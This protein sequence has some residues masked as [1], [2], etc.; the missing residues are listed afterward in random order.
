MTILPRLI[1]PTSR[2]PARATR[3]GGFD[4]SGAVRR[5]ANSLRKYQDIPLRLHK[6]WLTTFLGSLLL[7]GVV[8]GI[9]LNLTARTAIA[10]REIQNLEVQIVT[11]QRLNADLQTKIAGLL[12]TVTLDERAAADGYVPVQR[13][14]LQYLLVPGYNPG[15]AAGMLNST[16]PQTKQEFPSEYT[17]TLFVWLARQ[18]D[19]ASTPLAQTH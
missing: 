13:D 17:E 6:Q 14:D 5:A 10:G 15:P 16:A 19:F 2:R 7:I 1:S 11:N 3:Q 12:S 8:A 4:V 9:Y 18:L